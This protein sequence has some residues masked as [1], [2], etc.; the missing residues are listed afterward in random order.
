MVNMV[1]CWV[2][3]FV[4]L[5]LK[6][7]VLHHLWNSPHERRKREGV[8]TGRGREKNLDLTVET[9]NVGTVPFSCP[10]RKFS[11]PGLNLTYLDVPSG[12]HGNLSFHP[13]PSFRLCSPRNRCWGRCSLPCTWPRWGQYSAC[14]VLYSSA[15]QMTPSCTCLFPQMT[16]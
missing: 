10:R 6:E 16:P 13:P 8:F 2:Y 11:D 7:L 3:M 5:T 1:L 14:V 15:M 9:L 12:C 4:N